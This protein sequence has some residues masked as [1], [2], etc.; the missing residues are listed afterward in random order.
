MKPAALAAS[1]PV[2]ARAVVLTGTPVV[3]FAG[4]SEHQGLFKPFI[5]DGLVLLPGSD[6]KVTVKILRETES[7]ESFILEFVLPFS[8][9]SHTGNSLLI[10]RI[11]LNT[12]SIPLH[13]VTLTCDLLQGDV[14]FGVRAVDGVTLILGNNLAGGC[15][16]V[17]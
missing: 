8:T 10:R 16:W 17:K 7:S 14:E 13:R 9:E 15:V 2:S 3:A 4:V 5:S 11:G 1:V 12:L 6:N